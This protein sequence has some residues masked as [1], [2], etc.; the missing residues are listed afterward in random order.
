MKESVTISS[1]GELSRSPVAT[2]P[3]SRTQLNLVGLTL[4]GSPPPGRYCL[5][6]TVE[7]IDTWDVVIIGG[8]PP[9]E[10]VGQYAVAGSDRTVVIVEAEL[11]G[12]ECS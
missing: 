2:V 1:L 8:G 7:S 9:A 6:V 5:W 11:G 4:L 10:N 3:T 12:G